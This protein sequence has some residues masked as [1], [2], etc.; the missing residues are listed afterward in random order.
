MKQIY[1]LLNGYD[2]YYT[3]NS[4]KDIIFSKERKDAKE[5]RDLHDAFHVV[6]FINNNFQF[7]SVKS[8]FSVK[9]EELTETKDTTIE[10][11]ENNIEIRNG[12]P[13]QEYEFITKTK[14]DK[15]SVDDRGFISE[16]Y[17]TTTTIV[18]TNKDGFGYSE[19]K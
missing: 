17:Y 19:I 1:V 2:F 8:Y 11:R 3:E 18:K 12:N 9:T 10:V 4:G 16:V 6:D 13:N 5:Y 15:N 14:V 7:N